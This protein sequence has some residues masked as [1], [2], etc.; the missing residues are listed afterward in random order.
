MFKKQIYLIIIVGIGLFSLTSYTFAACDTK[1]L[2][3]ELAQ[4]YEK[5]LTQEE[6]Y[7]QPFKAKVD[8][9]GQKR[10]WSQTQIDTYLAENV[11][12][13]LKPGKKQR[14]KIREKMKKVLFMAALGDDNTCQELG[15]LSSQ[16][17]ALLENNETKWAERNTQI[18]L[19]LS[20]D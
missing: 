17:R 12:G 5:V 1:E 10:G 4:T 2:A 6:Q 18:D 16:L 11:A 20:K 3:A 14:K 9:L 15:S 8:Q 7:F 19:K 13:I